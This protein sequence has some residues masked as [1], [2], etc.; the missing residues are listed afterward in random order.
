MAGNSQPVGHHW[1][2]HVILLVFVFP[3][4][5]GIALAQQEGRGTSGTLPVLKEA[6]QVREL[7]SEKA[8]LGYPIQLHAVVTYADFS[9]GDLFVQDATAGIYV[10]PANLALQLRAGQYVEV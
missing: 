1:S 2:V 9:H 7:S 3:F 5:A 8:T 6:R 4:L 10:N